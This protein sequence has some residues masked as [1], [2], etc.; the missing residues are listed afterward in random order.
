MD[1]HYNCAGH[2]WASRR[3]CI[4][5]LAEWRKI[6]ED[7]GYQRT[8]APV[9]DDIVIYY[10]AGL[11]THVARVHRLIENEIGPPVPVVISKWGDTGG[12]VIHIVS[13]VPES[14]RGNYE[15][16]TDRQHNPPAITRAIILST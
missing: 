5:E 1:L 11:M 7:D 10:M 12:E 3:T 14:I 9:P 6:L 13:E 16:W 15:Y 2:V 8:S 4:Y